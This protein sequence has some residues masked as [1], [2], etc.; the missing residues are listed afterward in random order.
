MRCRLCSSGRRADVDLRTRGNVVP[1]FARAVEKSSTSPGVEET[2]SVRSWQARIG[3][4]T[5]LL[6]LQS[7]CR[8]SS[9]TGSRP[10]GAY[11]S[12]HD[13]SP[14]RERGQEGD[15]CVRTRDRGDRATWIEG[16]TSSSSSASP[17]CYSASTRDVFGIRSRVQIRRSRDATY[18]VPASC[19]VERGKRRFPQCKRSSCLP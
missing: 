9:N 11:M 7:W 8:G 5:D 16:G 10:H 17:C 19:V 2:R 15:G 14:S 18:R 6:A 4:K 13:E 1:R 12:R 3:G